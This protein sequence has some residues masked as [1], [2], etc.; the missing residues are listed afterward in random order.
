[1]SQH[2]GIAWRSLKTAIVLMAAAVAGLFTACAAPRKVAQSGGQPSVTT[3]M[4][5]QLTYT[6][7]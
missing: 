1:M 7:S 5:P 4:A 6:T 3:A 2:L